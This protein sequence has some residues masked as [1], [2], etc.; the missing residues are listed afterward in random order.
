[1]EQGLR[2]RDVRAIEACDDGYRVEHGTL[3]P[4]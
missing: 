1:M 3:T 4:E 2:L